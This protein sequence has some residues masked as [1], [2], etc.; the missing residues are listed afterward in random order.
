MT[1]GH[2]LHYPGTACSD[3]PKGQ[4]SLRRWLRP[5]TVPPASPGR[6]PAPA[7]GQLAKGPHTFVLA[8]HLLVSAA[9]WRPHRLC[10]AGRAAPV[11][12][13]GSQPSRSLGNLGT[14]HR[15]LLREGAERSLHLPPLLVTK[16]P[17]LGVGTTPVK[18]TDPTMEP[19]SRLALI[20][21]LKASDATS[22]SPKN[23]AMAL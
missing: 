23:Y 1:G 19:L 4:V 20:P 12:P 10:S 7:S 13:Q 3:E 17:Y 9:G 6:R 2:G 8:H 14:E 5:L 18:G 21:I 16:R 15:P 22:C 11:G